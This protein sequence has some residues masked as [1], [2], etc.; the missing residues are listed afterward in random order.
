LV[1]TRVLAIPPVPFVSAYLTLVL[2][3]Q[4]CAAFPLLSLSS[5]T[6]AATELDAISSSSNS[7]AASNTT[8]SKHHWLVLLNSWTVTNAVHCVRTLANV[9]QSKGSYLLDE[10]GKLKAMT[11]WEQLE[12]T[13]ESH[14]YMRRTLLIMPTVLAYT[15]CVM[16]QFEPYT[17]ALAQSAH[18]VR[19]HGG[20]IAH[21][22]QRPPLWLRSDGRH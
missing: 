8:V 18:L 17:S 16:V 14:C 10:Q 22:E 7:S 12:A 4:I 9:H 6:A 11:V 1:T 19:G 15:A 20:P 2:A 21:Y 3:I 13:S 5:S